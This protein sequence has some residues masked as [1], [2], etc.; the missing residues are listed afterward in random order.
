MLLL[1]SRIIAHVWA[2]PFCFGR[3]NAVFM[4]LLCSCIIAYMW[5]PP[6][7]FGRSNAVFM[8][9][10]CDV[11]CLLPHVVAMYD[12]TWLLCDVT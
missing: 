1:C 5:P 10:P 7:C 3:S 8:L 4:L 6:F 12:V 9:L 11:M 2:P